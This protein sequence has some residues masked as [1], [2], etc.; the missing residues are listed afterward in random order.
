MSKIKLSYEDELALLSPEEQAARAARRNPQSQAYMDGAAN[1]AAPLVGQKYNQEAEEVIE[2][3]PVEEV[4]KTPVNPVAERY[5]KLLS[6]L[7]E[8]QS[9]EQGNLKN[10]NLTRG[11]NQ[12]A[13]GFAAM[14]GGKISD[15]NET[16]DRLADTAKRPVNDL[17]TQMKSVQ[18]GINNPD[19]QVV[20]LKD[21]VSGE[22]KSYLLNKRTG[23]KSPLGQTGYSPYMFKNDA[24]GNVEA[25]ARQ[26]NTPAA[27]PQEGSTKGLDVG[28]IGAAFPK[29]GGHIRKLQEDY[30]TD[31]KDYRTVADAYTNIKSKINVKPGDAFP[32][33]GLLGSIQTQS[34]I[35]AGNKGVL[36]DQDLNK[37]AGAG[38][39][40]AWVKRFLSG[41][42]TGEM[43]Q[44]DVNFFN[45]FAELMAKAGQQSVNDRS[46]IFIKKGMG[47]LRNYFPNIQDSD[48]KDLL[49]VESITPALARA[50]VPPDEQKKQMVLK[51]LQDPNLK[52]EKA[53]ALKK[54]YGL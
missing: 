6:Q 7:A 34:A 12:I 29:V 19:M 18:S 49:G 31:L 17:L 54:K 46:Q 16:L 40:A 52:P 51:L 10:I 27:G 20:N 50:N 32:D 5:E 3:T 53:E 9:E 36:S 1:N 4:V 39:A 26:V 21:P 37:Y 23:Q 30:L 44:D 24:T 43:S 25:K 22:T 13:Q 33:S 14:N 42:M 15:G 38:G 2:E 8:K 35:L 41:S 45:R 11:G 48:V 28:A 47:E